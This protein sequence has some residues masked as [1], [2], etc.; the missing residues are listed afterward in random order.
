MNENTFLQV[1]DKACEL[2]MVKI[3][4]KAF[5]RKQFSSA[6]YYDCIDDILV[7]GPVCA[8]V[9][10]QEIKKIAKNCIAYESTKVTALSFVAG[11][12]GGFAMAGTIPADLAQYYAHI[13]RIMQKLMYLYGWDDIG[14][15][16]EG[17]KNVL[18]IFLGVMSG[19]QGVSSVASKLCQSAS[20]RAVKSIAA[21]AL[22]KGTLYP[23]VKKI[24]TTL[25]G[26]MTKEIFAKG[27]AKIIPMAGGF[28]S[29]GL[30]LATFTPMANKLLK[31]MDSSI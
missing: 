13:F 4:R 20:T 25:G 18:I 11:V 2:P 9:S 24:S 19:V 22:T 16:D 8:N 28:I 21:K 27:T 6:R 1:V 17:T 30:T 14:N 10:K 5:L 31:L 26:K 3:D 7:S 15:M 12:P 29:S 23:I